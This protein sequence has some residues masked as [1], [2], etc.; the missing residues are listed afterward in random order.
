MMTEG[1]SPCKP[2]KSNHKIA[3]LTVLF[4]VFNTISTSHEGLVL[5]GT[6]QN[7]GEPGTRGF[8]LSSLQHALN[9]WQA[10]V[11]QVTALPG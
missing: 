2:L 8:P 6:R 3:I 9:Q 5:R 11:S 4:A 7:S 10:K 1:K